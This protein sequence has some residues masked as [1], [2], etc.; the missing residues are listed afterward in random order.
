MIDERVDERVK[1]IFGAKQQASRHKTF[2]FSLLLICMICFCDYKFL[3]L[4]NEYAIFN[5]KHPTSMTFYI[6]PTGTQ[7]SRGF[8]VHNVI[9]CSTLGRGKA[10][11]TCDQSG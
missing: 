2:I 4:N 5:K 6:R 10:C 7:I 11:P 9:M 3:F 1:P 8:K